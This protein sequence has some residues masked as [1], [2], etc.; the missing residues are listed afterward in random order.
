[1]KTKK[2]DAFEAIKTLKQELSKHIKVGRIQLVFDDN[3]KNKSM[4][5]IVFY[6]KDGDTANN[7]FSTIYSFNSNLSFEELLSKCID[8][9]KSIN[10]ESITK[11]TVNL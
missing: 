1:M 6:E 3:E 2:I 10:P 5:V 4:E 8:K 7:F 9:V 11:I